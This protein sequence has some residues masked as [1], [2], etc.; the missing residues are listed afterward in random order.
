VG[1]KFNDT[2]QLLAYADY[3]NLLGN[4]INTIRKNA[5]TLIDA[6]KKVGLGINLD[7][8]KYMALSRRQNIGQNRDIKIANRSFENMSQ[9]K[10]LGTKVTNQNLIQEKIKSL[11]SGNVCCHSVQNLL[12]SR[13]LSKTSERRASCF[14]LFAKYN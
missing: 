2:H 14:V 6:R 13:L 10:Y 9:L 7:K 11:D 1:L 3:V 5:E 8:T 12:S 4:N